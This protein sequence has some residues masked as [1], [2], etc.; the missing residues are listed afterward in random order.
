MASDRYLA[1]LSF[2]FWVQIGSPAA[3]R[4]MALGPVRQS[5]LRFKI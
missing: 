3:V 1:V 4:E 2:G 5:D